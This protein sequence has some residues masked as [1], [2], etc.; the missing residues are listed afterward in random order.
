M[1]KSESRYL[2]VKRFIMDGI[3]TGQWKSG[4]QVPSE[5]E[6]VNLCKVSRMT[7]RRALEELDSEGILVRVR[8]KGSFVAEEK[9]QSSLLEIKNIKAEITEQGFQHRAVLVEMSSIPATVQLA[10]L[11]KLTEGTHIYH[12][13]I[14]HYQD[15]EPVQM[16]ERFINPQVAADYLNQDFKTITP[17]EYLTQIAPVTEAEHVIEAITP[18]KQLINLLQLES[19]EAVLLLTRTTWSFEQA[20]SFAKLYHPGKRYR[21]QSRFTPKS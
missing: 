5:N 13:I 4:Q 15:H 16:E 18:E 21:L 19:E 2:K 14:V 9:H 8:G 1:Q 6:L 20:V 7:A 10:E 17:N 3:R 12:S 11:F